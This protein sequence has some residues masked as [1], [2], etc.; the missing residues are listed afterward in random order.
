MTNIKCLTQKT[1]VDEN[2]DVVPLATILCLEICDQCSPVN[3]S[4]R[5]RTWSSAV[6]S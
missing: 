5:L 2:E 3:H 1:D 4:Q 6:P